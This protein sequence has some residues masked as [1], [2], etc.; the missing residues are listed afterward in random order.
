[1]AFISVYSRD[2]RSDGITDATNP[3]KAVCE[4]RCS[5]AE[6]GP[7]QKL[8]GSQRSSAAT[9]SLPGPGRACK[10]VRRIRAE[11]YQ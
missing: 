5:I 7:R 3:A 11:N 2:A 8:N 4:R 1:M 6:P 9:Y 10:A